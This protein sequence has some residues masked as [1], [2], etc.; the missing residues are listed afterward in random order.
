VGRL[1]QFLT[2][3]ISQVFHKYAVFGSILNFHEI[4]KGVYLS[5]HSVQIFI[6]TYT[7]DSL[8]IDAV[9]YQKLALKNKNWRIHSSFCKAFRWKKIMLQIF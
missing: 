2:T 7:Q 1:E 5:F 4:C 9:V 6:L 8:D 3:T